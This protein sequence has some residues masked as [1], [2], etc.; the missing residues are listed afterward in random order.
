MPDN[1]REFINSVIAELTTLWPELKIVHGKPR[2]SQSQGS[3][4]RANQDIKNMLASW[5]K[6]NHATNWSNGL[7]YV[8][9]MKIRS[10]HSGIKQSPYKAIFRIEPR[11][12]LTSELPSAVIKHFHDEDGLQDVMSR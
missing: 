9:F 1:G 5:M 10:L 6:E 12:G 3:V 2:H 8:Q 7:R 11:V 4:E